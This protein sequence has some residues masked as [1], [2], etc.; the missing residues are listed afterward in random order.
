MPKKSSDALGAPADVVVTGGS[1]GTGRF[2]PPGFL[3]AFRSSWGATGRRR[4]QP[5]SG[6]SDDARQ[7]NEVDRRER[8]I[9]SFLGIFQLIV[10]VLGYLEYHRVVVHASTKKPKISVHKAHLETL[11]YHHEAPYLLLVDGVLALFIG[12]AVLLRRRSLVG[13]AVLLGGFGLLSYGGGILGIVYIGVG[14]WLVFRAM[15]RTPSSTPA[16]A[17]ATAEPSGSRRLSTG[18]LAADKEELRRGARATEAAARTPPPASKRYTPPRERPASKKKGAS[19]VPS[20]AS[21]E[22]EEKRSRLSR[23]FGR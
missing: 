11:A 7:V 10:A 14:L 6:G 16:A 18:S 19:Q 1:S 8:L 12:I 3:D 20:W 13:F 2:Q 23:L 21:G 9:A 17:T 4:A 5:A 22:E 15:R